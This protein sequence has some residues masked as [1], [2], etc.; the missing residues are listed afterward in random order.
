M[1]RPVPFHTQRGATLVVGLIMLVLITLM[2]TSAFMLSTT[3]LKSVGNMQFRDE[4]L[5][6]ADVAIERMLNSAGFYNSTGVL[7]ESVDIN[8]DGADDYVVSIAPFSGSM[9][10]CVRASKADM[11]VLSSVTLGSGMSK[12][13]AWN[14]IY[15]IDAT[16]TPSSNNAGASG[17]SVHVHSGVRVLFPTSA[18]KDAACK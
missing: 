13:D 8:N 10:K 12:S 1:S 9:S 18:A 11:A 2:L 16:V 7:T 14:V 15:D 6:A 4:A 17:T 5:A 3:N